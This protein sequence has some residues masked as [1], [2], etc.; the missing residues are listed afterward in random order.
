[1]AY[2]YSLGALILAHVARLNRLLIPILV[3]DIVVKA[4][5]TKPPS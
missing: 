1:M 2:Q 4:I 5:T 3:V